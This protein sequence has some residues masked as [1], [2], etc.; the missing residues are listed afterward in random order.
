MK[1][2][3]R[4]L[5]THFFSCSTD[6]SE[7]L[8]GK[9]FTRTNK[10]VIVNNAIEASLY[11][12]NESQRV[13]I[14]TERGWTDKFVVGHVGRFTHAKNHV[15]ILDIFK[16]INRMH[17]DSILVLVGDGEDRKDIE[18]KIKTEGLESVVV[19]AGSVGNVHE[20]VQAM[21]VF[22]FPSLHEGLGMALIEAQA[23]GLRCFASEDGVP[24]EAAIT[25]LVEYIPLSKGSKYW[26][27]RLLQYKK[28][29]ERRNTYEEVMKSGY[30][31]K[32]NAVWLQNY[33]M[34]SIQ[35]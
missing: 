21:D 27:E 23:A 32:Q 4:K 1:F 7:W 11:T 5:A 13:H 24:K 17:P 33:Y 30:D 29:Y 10:V 22:L 35:R 15:F 25:D 18:E 12:F 14:R 16:E 26:S 19:L 34:K 3:L 2:F 9:R 28:G 31:V 6:A 20:Y 8:Y